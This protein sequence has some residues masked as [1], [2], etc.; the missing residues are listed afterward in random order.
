MAAAQ[1]AGPGQQ[2]CDG[3]MTTTETVRECEGI[4]RARVAMAASDSSVVETRLPAVVVEPERGVVT[5]LVFG[6]TAARPAPA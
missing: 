5:V 1:A 6:W 2:E 4:L 3:D